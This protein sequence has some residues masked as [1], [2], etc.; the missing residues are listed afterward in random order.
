M[1]YIRVGF[2]AA[3]AIVLMTVALANRGPVTF[4]LLP[5]DLGGLMGF[6]WSITVPLY[7]VIF[8][9]IVAGLA[10]G[11][12]AEWLREYRYRSTA[13][14]EHRE[15]ERLKREVKDLKVDESKGDDVLALLDAPRRT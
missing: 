8:V 4:N 15:L 11:Y 7:L 10:I 12:M 3:L 5:S 2:W 9:A 6:N 1:F 14:R 13:S